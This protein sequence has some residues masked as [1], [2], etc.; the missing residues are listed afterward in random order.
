MKERVNRLFITS[1][2]FF[3]KSTALLLILIEFTSQ[4]TAIYPGRLNDHNTPQAD[5]IPID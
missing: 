2:E 1:T 4:S 5:T 3:P